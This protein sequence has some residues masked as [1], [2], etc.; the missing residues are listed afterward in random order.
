MCRNVG[1]KSTFPLGT[2]TVAPCLMSGPAAI[3]VLCISNGLELP[4]PAT[5]FDALVPAMPCAFLP[6]VQSGE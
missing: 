5:P 3:S 4:W 6:S 1:A 2:F